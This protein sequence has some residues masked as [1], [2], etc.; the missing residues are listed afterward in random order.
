MPMIETASQTGYEN[1][2]TTSYFADVAPI[3]K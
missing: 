1:E 2:Q 3:Q